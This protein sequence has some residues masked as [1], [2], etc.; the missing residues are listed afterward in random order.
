MSVMVLEVRADGRVVAEFNGHE[1][2]QVRAGDR[3]LRD[4]M[5]ENVA[6]QVAAG[7]NTGGDT[8]PAIVT[9]YFELAQSVSS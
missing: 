6:N 8:S 3:V 1:W 5:R 4:F 9:S 7:Y 2:F